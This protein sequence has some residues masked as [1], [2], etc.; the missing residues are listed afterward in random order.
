MTTTLTDRYVYAATRWLPGKTRT[1]VAEELRER[2]GDTVAAR[3]A[4]PAAERETLEELGDPLRV[5]VDY[6]GRAPVLIGPRLFF[7]WLRLTMLLAAIVGPIVAA[8]VVIVAAFDGDSIGTI[9]GDGVG[10]LF[11]VTVH[12]IFWTTLVF[13]VLD[14]TNTSAGAQTWSIDQLSEP[15]PGTSVS[16][17]VAGLVFLPLFA[18]AILWQHFGSPFFEDGDRIAM[19]DPDLWSWYLPWV[20]GVL[21]LELLHLLWVYRSGWTWTTAWANVVLSLLFAIPTIA[22]LLDNALINPELVAH[23]SSWDPEYIATSMKWS[24]A[25]VALVSLWEIVDGFRK[26]YVTARGRARAQ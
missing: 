15:K 9:V 17:L 4:T 3:G 11:D 16:D 6:T 24:A 18:A 2:I 14:W 25:I 26:A 8:I 5:A 12:V 19:I 7:P 13:A 20:L 1:E 10:T 22:L 21:A 23:L